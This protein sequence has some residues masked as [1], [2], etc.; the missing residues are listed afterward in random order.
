MSILEDSFVITIGGGGSARSG[1]SMLLTVLT[2]SAFWKESQRACGLV[3][4]SLAVAVG[5]HSRAHQELDLLEA[6][7]SQPIMPT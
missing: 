1:T 6:H 2:C 4:L 7:V 3:E 5:E